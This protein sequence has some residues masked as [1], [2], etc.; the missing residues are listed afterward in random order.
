[1]TNNGRKMITNYGDTADPK[2]VSYGK[3]LPEKLVIV[4]MVNKLLAFYGTRSFNTVVTRDRHWNL[5]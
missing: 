4:Q 3:F 2:I 1:M 5:S